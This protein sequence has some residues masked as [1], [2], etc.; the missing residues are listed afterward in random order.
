M[1]DCQAD[2]FHW[3]NDLE[4]VRKASGTLGAMHH[5][6]FLHNGFYPCFGSYILETTSSAHM[7][8]AAVGIT[9]I[10]ENVFRLPSVGSHT[11]DI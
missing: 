11:R 8:D 4:V 1:T 10:P 9:A 5:T 7:Q 3:L 6:W 2:R